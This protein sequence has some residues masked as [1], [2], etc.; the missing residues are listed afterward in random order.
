MVT[1]VPVKF[2]LDSIII[3]KKPQEG[4]MTMQRPPT[5]ALERKSETKEQ[6]LTALVIF[7][8]CLHLCKDIFQTVITYASYEDDDNT[9]NL[10]R[11]TLLERML[12]CIMHLVNEKY[13]R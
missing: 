10:K 9:L 2:L 7:V 1:Y 5:N 8:A 12:F 3:Q 4:I 6:C 11:Y 13:R